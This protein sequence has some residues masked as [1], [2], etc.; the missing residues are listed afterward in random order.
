M[1]TKLHQIHCNR[2]SS[3][4]KIKRIASLKHIFVQFCHQSSLHASI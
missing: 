4:R 3:P 2:H 1:Q